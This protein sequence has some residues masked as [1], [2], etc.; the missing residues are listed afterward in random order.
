MCSG[1]VS[2]YFFTFSSFEFSLTGVF[3]H[4]VDD[5]KNPSTD[6]RFSLCLHVK[7]HSPELAGQSLA[8]SNSNSHMN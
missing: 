3:A 4:G 7:I 1:F 6:F 8:I 5:E 2:R